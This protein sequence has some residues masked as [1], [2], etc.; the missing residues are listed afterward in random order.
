MCKFVAYYRVSTERQGLPNRHGLASQQAA[1]R[2]HIGEHELV[3]EFTE[4]ESGRNSARPRLAEAIALAKRTKSVL[5]IARLDRLAR[6]LAFVANLLDSTVEFCAADMPNANRMMLQMVAV[7]AEYEARLI[8]ERTRSALAAARARGVQLGN[9]KNLAKAQAAGHAVI[10]KQAADHA[11][12]VMPT[13]RDIVR[14]G[15]RSVHEV[16]DAMTARGVATRRG[17]RWTGSAVLKVVKR[18][19]FDGIKSLAGT[20]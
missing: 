7:M 6:N 4:I 16:A 17:G 19:G 15:A 8:S 3:A 20:L 10:V 13:I 1:V 18:S 12:A 5:I 11:A 14:S 2:A 9:R